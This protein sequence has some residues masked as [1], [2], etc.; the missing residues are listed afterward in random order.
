M[1]WGRNPYLRFWNARLGRPVAGRR[2]RSGGRLP[3]R[4]F[5]RKKKHGIVEI[6]TSIRHWVFDKRKDAIFYPTSTWPDGRRTRI[7]ETT[8]DKRTSGR[9][10]D[11]P[12][13]G[14]HGRR[15][16]KSTTQTLGTTPQARVQWKLPKS[17]QY[18]VTLLRLLVSGFLVGCL[19]CDAGTQNQKKRVRTAVYTADGRCT[20]T[21]Y[22]LLL[23]LLIARRAALPFNARSWRKV[24][25]AVRDRKWPRIR[26]ATKDPTRQKT[27]FIRHNATPQN[28][29]GTIRHP[30]KRQLAVMPT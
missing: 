20:H 6:Q 11:G 29:T 10:L 12:R 2:N 8:N 19:V 13:N 28:S 24:L 25:I 15:E 17:V 7:L 9:R 23:L 3:V 27:V 30:T 5:C 16:K 22:Y 14:L 26:S 4:G 1:R 18:I 21:H